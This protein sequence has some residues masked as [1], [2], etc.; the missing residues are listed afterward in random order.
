MLAG[1]AQGAAA[2][3][4]ADKSGAPTTLWYVGVG[5]AKTDAIPDQTVNGS[6]A[7]LSVPLGAAF[8][9]VDRDQRSTGLKL[10]LGYCRRNFAV[11]GGYAV[12]DK[13]SV[14]TDFRSG[15]LPSASVGTF[16]L[17]YKLTDPFVDAVG[18]LPLSDKWS[19]IGR[20]GVSY[21]RTSANFDGS[22][23]TLLASSN[24]KTE[25]KVREKFGAGVDYNIS[26]AVAVRA[27][28][29]RYKMPESA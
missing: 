15:A 25:S 6:N 16:N 19:L 1:I 29:E 9:I 4:L 5:I 18:I 14:H 28:W 22:P 17:K 23:L 3:Y 11:E 13:T 8:T 7:T 10:L 26:A 27:E 12:L 21:S 20:V 24:D 2:Q